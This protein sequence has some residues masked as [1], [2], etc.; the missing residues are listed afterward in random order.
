MPVTWSTNPPEKEGLRVLAEVDQ[1]VGEIK[2]TDLYW[3]EGEWQRE[4]GS[5]F[6]G[7]VLRWTP[8]EPLIVEVIDKRKPNITKLVELFRELNDGHLDDSGMSSKHCHTLVNRF[9]K[10]K[11]KF[12]DPRTPEEM[13]EH[14]M[15]LSKEIPE[16]AAWATS[17]GY[18]VKWQS[19][20]FN[21]IRKHNANPSKQSP[22]DKLAQ[23]LAAIDS[24][25]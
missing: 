10:L 19:R 12:N 24:Q 20:I 15:R 13:V 3:N 14:Y 9:T 25:Q 21:L 23:G 8:L 22:G 7:A 17:I 2:Y 6:K 5:P 16:V 4:I 1:L 18:L 11:E